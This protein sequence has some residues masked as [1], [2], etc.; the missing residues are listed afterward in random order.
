MGSDHWLY[1]ATK[2]PAELW[3]TV[4]VGFLPFFAP[5][6]YS[7]LLGLCTELPDFTWAIPDFGE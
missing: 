6:N 2:V 1:P 7:A 4:R 3:M 5:G